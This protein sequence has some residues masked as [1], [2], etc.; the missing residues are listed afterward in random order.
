MLNFE[1][2]A[3][4]ERRVLMKEGRQEG[5][6]EGL[7]EGRNEIIALLERIKLGDI[8]LEDALSKA[9]HPTQETQ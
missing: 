4:A 3:E 8:S 1:Y 7:Q 9:K 5:L 6:Q 2:D